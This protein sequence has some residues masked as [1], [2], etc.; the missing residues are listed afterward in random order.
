[1]ENS[2]NVFQASNFLFSLSVETLIICLVIR[3]FS[4][5]TIQILFLHCVH[6]T[7]IIYL[8][9]NLFELV[10]ELRLPSNNENLSF[11]GKESEKYFE[12]RNGKK[13]KELL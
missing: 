10:Y 12:Q 11:G 2:K 5:R 6:H 8:Q 13:S 4:S 7:I 3:S 1:M 9:R